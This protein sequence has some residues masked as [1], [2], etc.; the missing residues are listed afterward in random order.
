MGI[1]LLQLGRY[2]EAIDAYESAIQ[3]DANHPVFHYCRGD[4]LQRLGRTEEAR[5]AYERGNQ[6][7]KGLL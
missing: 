7:K 1:I 4:V 5:Q 3:I 2:P 6:L